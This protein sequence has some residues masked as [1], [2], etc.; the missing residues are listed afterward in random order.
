[1]AKINLS[2]INNLQNE[3]TATAT[4]NSNNT[5][6]AAAVENSISRDGTQP[7]Q[8]NSRLDMNSNAIINLPDATSDQ[9]PITYSQFLSGLAATGGGEAVTG[10]YVLLEHNSSM[11]N[12]RVLSAG[13]GIGII[14][15][16]P[17]GDVTIEV[18]NPQLNALSLALSDEDKLPYYTA[19]GTADVTDFTPFARTL[20]DDADSAAARAT[21]GIGLGTGDLVSTNNLSDVADVNV[22]RANLGAGTGD[23]D[24]LAS[25]NLSDVANPTLARGNIGAGVGNMLTATYDPS[26]VN[27]SAFLSSNHTYAP[28][29]TGATNRTAKARLDDIVSVINFGADRT[30]SGDSTTAINSAITYVNS[31]GGGT[32]YLP[33]GTYKITN[34]ITISNDH[35]NIVGAGVEATKIVPAFASARN[36]FTVGTTDYVRFADL[37]IRGDTDTLS[38]VSTGIQLGD[39]YRPTLERINIEYC[40]KNIYLA[41]GTSNHY[42]AYLHNVRTNFGG[43]GLQ[44]GE[45]GTTTQPW[46]NV[47]LQNCSFGA[48]TTQGVLI[49][50]VGGLQWNEGEIIF[51][52]ESMRVVPGNGQKAGGMMF[53]NVYFDTPDVSS[54]TFNVGSAAAT[55]Q[56]VDV[57]FTGCS[58]NN[59]QGTHGMSIEGATSGTRRV[60]GIRF[61]G[62]SFVIN[63]RQGLYMQGVRNVDIDFC[64]FVSNSVSASNSYDG[65]AIGDYCD[66]VR[67]NGGLSGKRV[68]FGPF[69]RY[70]ISLTAT[71]TNVTI[72]DINLFDNLTAGL[73]DFGSVG[74]IVKD[75]K[76]FRTKNR[77]TGFF[78]GGATTA[79]VTHGLDAAPD[80]Q[81]INIQEVQDFEGR[82]LWIS[83]VTSTTFT[84][85]MSSSLATDRYFTWIAEVYEK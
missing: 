19:V 70:G 75:V 64:H 65:L 14:D 73:K 74:L 1:M 56:I 54:I 13:N 69:Q 40:V 9:E 43:T 83:A 61:I 22:A 81:R 62:C 76:G 82:R 80:N 66:Q 51:G 85:S 2:P 47:L 49:Y 68:D 72:K 29:G 32:V 38:R 15:G 55:G 26:F 34:T 57:T 7:N 33:A 45:S 6:I 50:A 44:I 11:T 63:A 23:G 39:C 16:G 77:G 20:L 5:I 67:V 35:I 48:A 46:Q 28:A 52:A 36:A 37:T 21:L 41:T 4:I 8:M 59:A 31:L 18:N 12:D 10:D 53:T 3:S 71:S 78:A 58:I 25:N 17:K 42:H 60:E 79:V 27:G 24:L 30:G 84:V